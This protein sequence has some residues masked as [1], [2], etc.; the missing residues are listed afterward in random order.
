MNDIQAQ[1]MGY[2]K[3]YDFTEYSNQNNV[4]VIP[5]EDFKRLVQVTF[6]CI[7]DNLRRTYGPYASTVLISDQSETYATKDGYNVF[8][9]IGF[10]HTYKRMVYLAI[11][12][13]IDRVNK[14]VGDG[15]TSC[16]LL[17]E[18]LFEN[19]QKS[20]KTVDDK[21][22]L[23]SVLND[24]EAYL[25]NKE[26]I[27]VDRTDGLVKP[28]TKESLN[29][30]IRMA[31]NYDDKIVD[32]LVDALDPGYDENGCVTVIRN[33]VVD[34]QLER[35]SDTISYQVD[36][37]PGDYRIRVNMDPSF[38]LTFEQPRQVHVAL[39]ETVFGPDEWNF[40]NAGYDQK[41]EVIIIARSFSTT[42]LENEWKR[43]LIKCST[44]K[45]PVR[46][47]LCEIKGEYLR[48]ELKDLAAVLQTEL[49]GHQAVAVDIDE[50]PYVK[51]QVY[52]G[53]C[54]CFDMPVIPKQRIEVV[55]HDRDVDMSTS[56]TKMQWYEDRIKALS[57]ASRDTL[58]T[59]YA[60]STLE[61]KMVG[62]K[63]D[64][65]VS[66]VNSAMTYGVVPNLFA[67]G[68]WRMLRYIDMCNEHDDTLKTDAASAIIAAIR[69]LFDDVWYSKHGDRY[70]E[71]RD[72]IA[73]SFYDEASDVESF[74]I[75]KERFIPA[76]HL[77]TSAQYDLEVLAAAISIVKYLLTSNALVFDAFIMKQVDDTGHYKMM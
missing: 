47:I 66:I 57:N 9:A 46:I 6:K 70:D 67:Y 39:Y 23:M 10:S 71:K 52:N 19:L 1:E 65:C 42:F 74:D 20:I 41:S 45:I 37:L 31:G 30:L 22:N 29:G 68:Y 33:A 16:I 44:A 59:V 32:V 27:E 40:F 62:D 50:L 15:T 17:A 8:N 43:Y 28:L 60:T 55:K 12:K 38:A 49:N 26:E 21:R 61:K 5:E 56:L 51:V 13:I 53:I 25:L 7:A 72:Q 11:K 73:E 34:P 63:I 3:V 14:N 35:D 2:Q 69:G 77:P 48:E 58:V 54:M 18:K 75:I 64:D 76:D 4:N 24:I 36:Y